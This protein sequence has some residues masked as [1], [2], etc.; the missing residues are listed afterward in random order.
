V[1]ILINEDEDDKLSSDPPLSKFLDPPL[2]WSSTECRS[3]L[4]ESVNPLLTN[5][6]PCLLGVCKV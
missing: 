2:L 5:E 3:G 4:V 1:R 6:L